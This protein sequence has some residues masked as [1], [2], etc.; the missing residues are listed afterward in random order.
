MPIDFLIPAAAW[1][2]QGKS[3]GAWVI[4]PSGREG[5]EGRGPKPGLV[6]SCFPL[7]GQDGRKENCEMSKLWGSGFFFP[8][9]EKVERGAK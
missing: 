8:K 7:S 5:L 2:G 3:P 6:L 9:T 1:G 4:R